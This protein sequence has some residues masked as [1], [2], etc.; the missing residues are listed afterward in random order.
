MHLPLNQVHQRLLLGKI[1]IKQILLLKL[2]DKPITNNLL[3]T[4][5]L[6]LGNMIIKNIYKDTIINVT[7]IG[8]NN[9]ILLV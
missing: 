2:N 8:L 5:L 9:V 7:K 6:N 1:T 3:A 4:F